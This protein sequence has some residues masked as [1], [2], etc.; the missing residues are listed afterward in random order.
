MK[1]KE[2]NQEDDILIQSFLTIELLAELHN[3]K[4]LNSEYFNKLNIQDM[5]V[6][7]ILPQIGIDNQGFLLMALYALLVI[8]KQFL[9]KK[10]PDDFEALKKFILSIQVASQSTYKD[11]ER[12][13]NIDFV[14]HIRNA[15][16][17]GRVKFTPEISVTFSDKDFNKRREVKYSCEITIPTNQ[18][19][20]LISKLQIIFL[21]YIEQKNKL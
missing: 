5:N 15:V 1:Y 2:I 9:E 17:H 7:T 12:I 21:K 19:G 3:N 10:F 13:E 14:R 11:E 8:P 4:F 6:K 18:I 20:H 16:A